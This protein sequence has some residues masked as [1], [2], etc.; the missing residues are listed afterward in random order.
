[1]PAI[2]VLLPRSTEYPSMGFDLLDGIRLNLKRLGLTGYQVFTENTGFGEDTNNV[3]ALAEKLVL[4][5]DVDLIIAYATSLNAEALY[6]F[7]E[8]TNKPFLFLD[9]GMEIFEAPPGRLCRHLTLQGLMACQMLADKASVNK[10]KVIS[11]AS[12]FDGGYRSSWI[13]H[14]A[15]VKNGGSIC[16]HFVSNYRAE[17]FTLEQFVQLVGQGEARSVTAAFSS[18]FVGLFMEHLRATD[19]SV[20]QLPIYCSPF[21]ADEQLL[22]AINFPGATLPTIVPWAT[23]LDNA[24]N[25]VMMETMKKEKNKTANIFHL[26]GWEAATAAQRIIENNIQALDGWAFESPRGTVHFH[27]ETHNA[28]APLYE[29][30]IEADTNGKCKLTLGHAIEV[31]PGAHSELHFLRMPG[32]YSRWRNNFFCI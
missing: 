17:E 20:R 11:A 8:T 3:L 26:L 1:M 32:P 9:A 15:V 2:G 16:G 23:S 21:M 27:P 5:K 31:T 19:P 10:E 14:E 7:A 30:I 6:T 13:F 4:E 18:Y 29:G 25:R 22:Q 28:Y 12:F 24:E